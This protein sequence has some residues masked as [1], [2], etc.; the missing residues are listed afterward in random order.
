MRLKIVLP[1]GG[2]I[3]AILIRRSGYVVM[4]IYECWP[5]QPADEH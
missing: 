4:P 2:W 1:L 5:F 3:V